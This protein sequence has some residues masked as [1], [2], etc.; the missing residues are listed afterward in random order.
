MLKNSENIDNLYS[1]IIALF[2]KDQK[3]LCGGF[4]RRMKN[5]T[6]GIIYFMPVS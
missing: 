6:S 4:E 2:Q 1:S 5:F 3:K